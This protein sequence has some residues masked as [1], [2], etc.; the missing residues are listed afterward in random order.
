MTIKADAH[1]RFFAA[2]PEQAVLAYA[3]DEAFDV[4]FG[5][6]HGGQFAWILEPKSNIAERFG[7]QKEVIAFYSPHSKTDARMLTNIENFSS[8]PDF[9][10]RVDKV[11]AIVIHEGDPDG[12]VELFKQTYDWVIIPIHADELRDKHRGEFFL[13]SRLAERIGSFDLFGMSSPIKH[14]KYFFGRDSL[15]QEVMQRIIVRQENSGIFG[16][17]KTGKTSV[18]FALQRRL[19]DHNILVEY[20][21]CQGPGLYG[22]RWWQLLAEISNRLQVTLET[23]YSIKIKD[24]GVYDKDSAANSFNRFIKRI[25]GFDKINQICL[26]FD[27]IEFLTPTISNAL[28]QH[29]DDDFVPFWQ[30]IRSISQEVAGKITFIVAGVNPSCVE[31]PHFGE[32]QNPIFQLAIPYYLELLSRPS[33]REMIRSIGKYSGF[34]FDEDVYD[35]LRNTY[36]GHPYLVRLACSEVGRSKGVV[37]T[38]KKISITCQDFIE[39]RDRI[40]VRLAQP[41]KDILLSLVW[42]YPEDYE[43]LLILADG[44]TAFVVDYLRQSPGETV[45]FVRYGLVKEEDGTFA[46]DD[47]HVFLEE[48]GASYKNEISPFKRGDLPPEVL[49][50]TADLNDLAVL[51]EKRTEIEVALRKYII[52]VLGFKFGFDD[53]KIS[54]KISKG[55]RV[56]QGMADLSQLFVGRRPQDAINELFLSDLKPLYKANWDDVAPVFEKKIDRF[57]MNMDT[58]NIARRYEAHAKPVPKIDKDDFINS[59]SWF[60]TRLSKVPGLFS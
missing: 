39:Q 54:E 29:W 41:I 21:D 23:K 12:A 46:I 35:L 3:L 13:R 11:V 52:M 26:L 50:E 36:G 22:S 14:D 48:R 34:S 59:Y 53:S 10:H 18:L 2:H 58:I 5:N 56:R 49:P 60:K 7:L 27:E 15:V 31:R 16:L 8:S 25:L 17:R 40:R 37:P 44:D 6:Q 51:F 43:L 28:G 30:T 24:D 42:W 1:A 4:T 33:I 47:L 55:L 57:E 38:D 45:Q 20:M 19:F 9:R 32:I